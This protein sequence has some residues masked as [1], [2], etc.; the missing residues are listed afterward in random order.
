MR[1]FGCSTWS[2][3]SDSALSDPFGYGG[4]NRCDVMWV[5]K[6]TKKLSFG[7]LSHLDPPCGQKSVDLK[8]NIVLY[9]I[10]KKTKIRGQFSVTWNFV[11]WYEVK[12]KIVFLIHWFL[13]T[14]W[15]WSEGWVKIGRLPCIANVVEEKCQKC[16]KVIFEWLR[17]NF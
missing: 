10:P 15:V 9:F 11:F 3:R 12:V 5:R 6:N 17:A 16:C 14:W 13:A 1:V 7:S 8:N 2:L 4:I